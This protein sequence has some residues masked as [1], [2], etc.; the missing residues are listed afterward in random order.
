MDADKSQRPD[1]SGSSVP[2]P[3]D[4]LVVVLTTWP[5][6]APLETLAEGFVRDGLAAC[7]TI[8]PPHR[9]VYRWQGQIEFAD[10]QQLLLKSTREHLRALEAAIHA[11]HPYDVPE[12]LVLDVLAASGAYGAWM[13]G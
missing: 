1:F 2:P 10:E 6:G 3:T 12:F 7:V 9:S 11:V 8:L 4:G 5:V 13:R